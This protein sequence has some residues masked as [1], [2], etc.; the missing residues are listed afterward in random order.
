MPKYY[1]QQNGNNWKE[2]NTW[3][4]NGDWAN[5]LYNL[6]IDGYRTK[7]VSTS[8]CGPS[9]AAMVVSSVKG[10]KFTPGQMC[11]F[12]KRKGCRVAGGTA[13]SLFSKVGKEWN[14][15]YKQLS[16][17]TQMF[18]YL[19]D[20]WWVIVSCTGGLWSGGGHYILVC[21]VSNDSVEVYDPYWY[22]S[23]PSYRRWGSKVRTTEKT[24]K[25]CGAWITIENFKTYSGAKGWYAFKV[26]NISNSGDW[27]TYSKE[28]LA[29]M[30]GWSI[31]LMKWHHERAYSLLYEISKKDGNWENYFTDKK[32]Q[33]YKDLKSG[34]QTAGTK[35]KSD[36]HPLPDT[37]VYKAIQGMLESKSG[38]QAQREKASADVQAVIDELSKDYKVKNPAII[39]YLAD[40][41]NQN[42]YGDMTPVKKQ[43]KKISANNDSITKQLDS[44]VSWCEKNIKTFSSY[45]S[46][47][48]VTVEYIK[49]L[50]DSGRIVKGK[51]TDL[52]VQ[53]AKNGK[54]LKALSEKF[55]ITEYWTG[56]GYETTSKTGSG[57]STKDFS[58]IT[59]NGKKAYTYN[60]KIVVACATKELL[61][62]GYSKN[63]AQKN[64]PGK[65]YFQYYD[66]I[67]ITLGGKKYDAIVLD[68]C[69]AAMW[70]GE[71]RIDIFVPGKGNSFDQK[72]STCYIYEDAPASANGNSGSS[73]KGQYS[74]PFSG[75]ASV[76][77]VWG[78]NGYHS[79]KVKS[80]TSAY[81]NTHYHTGVDYSMSTGREL[82]ACTSG[83]IK[84]LTS[85]G[86][87]IAIMADDGNMIIY[88]HCSKRIAKNGATVKK[89]DVIAKSGNT[90]NS[91]G[92]H[93][94]FEVR[95]SPHK[96]TDNVN[97]LPYIDGGNNNKLY[98]KTVKY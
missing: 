43:A 48:S 29:K 4:S 38:K 14:I 17:S 90:G 44:M 76:S 15:E 46:R 6:N 32:I 22:S 41:F 9:C 27:T 97:P 54:I 42:R 5:H 96:E 7:T 18:K 25:T 34:S 68:S 83:K 75:S 95:K 26:G 39:I 33:L 60:G 50:I 52:G 81:Y 64:Q 89:G 21:G 2:G 40:L 82:K 53:K 58:T 8:G 72:N 45:A 37:K 62:S 31:G 73:G 86:L 59:I 11:D 88:G 12:S 23:K 16:N 71:H 24:I 36:F 61:K 80:K 66:E 55:Q 78:N 1:F 67:V 91:L 74:K 77:A 69:G 49:K 20:G 13:A 56:D 65:H 51:L 30:G 70:E 92:P 79:Y 85:Y 3:H 35:Y 57:K 84:H 94:H 28:Q 87:G 98:G 47:S 10:T 93:L 63:N 19:K